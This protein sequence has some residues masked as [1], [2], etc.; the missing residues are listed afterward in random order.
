M[1]SNSLARRPPLGNLPLAL[2]GTT[3][4]AAAWP[5][6]TSRIDAVRCKQMNEMRWVEN[7]TPN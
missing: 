7:L 5:R 1:R 2:N 4:K 6:G 3:T